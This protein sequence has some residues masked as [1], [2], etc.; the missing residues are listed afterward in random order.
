MAEDQAIIT[1]SGGAG[2]WVPLP[3]TRGD[4]TLAYTTDPLHASLAVIADVGVRPGE[5]WWIG[6]GG[7]AG[8][9]WGGPTWAA[10]VGVGISEPARRTMSMRVD[11]CSGVRRTLWRVSLAAPNVDPMPF[12]SDVDLVIGLVGGVAFDH[13]PRAFRRIEVGM[14]VSASPCG[15]TRAAV[16]VVVVS[17][18]F[19]V[20]RQWPG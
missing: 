10:E 9:A 3:A 13:G 4:S 1:L 11:V 7:G 5:R 6:V 19:L 12:A 18:G 8:V 15:R 20:G 16:P 2:A 17:T 14:D